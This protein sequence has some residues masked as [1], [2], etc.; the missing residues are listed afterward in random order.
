M[1][2]RRKTS[3]DAVQPSREGPF[4]ERAAYRS[5]PVDLDFDVSDLGEMPVRMFGCELGEGFDG[6][7]G[8]GDAGRFAEG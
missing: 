8:R 2:E 1:R 6:L 7:G 5:E 4:R 3:T